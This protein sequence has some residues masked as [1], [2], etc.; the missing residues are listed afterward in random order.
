MYREW[1]IEQAEGYIHEVCAQIEAGR[2][3]NY[4]E[5]E[6][7]NLIFPLLQEG[8]KVLVPQ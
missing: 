8:R 7:V 5:N 4:C 3:K 1:K 2:V 6:T